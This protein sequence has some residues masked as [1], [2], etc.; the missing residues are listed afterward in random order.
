M[1]SS[2]YSVI[3]TGS[4]ASASLVTSSPSISAV[5][6]D[7]SKLYRES[8]QLL[9]EAES[10]IRLLPTANAETLESAC[11]A[12]P[13]RAL[14]FEA[15]GVPWNVQSLVEHLRSLVADPV[16]VG[17][18]AN[19]HL[20]HQA[21]DGVTYVKRTSSCHVFVSALRGDDVGTA[22]VKPVRTELSQRTPDSLTQRELQVLA[23]ISG[24]W[25][26]AQIGER[27]GISTKSVENRKQ[28]LFVKL[29]VQNQSHAVAVA[30]R[31][32]LMGSGPI[33]LGSHE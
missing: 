28:S 29:G 6:Q 11:L 25:T 4:K 20:R 8:V 30:I 16:L 3:P 21:I 10:T 5:I 23:L 9:V 22:L 7:R 26:T 27:L 18:Y 17:T 2:S 12:V 24:G 1:H 32:G 33:N 15:S 19:E 13:V 31:T 14:V